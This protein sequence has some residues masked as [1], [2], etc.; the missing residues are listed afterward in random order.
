VLLRLSTGAAILLEG[1]ELS[2]TLGLAG[3]SVG[4]LMGA[5]AAGPS[6]LITACCLHRDETGWLGR[7]LA[8]AEGAAAGPPA[9]G[10]S[11]GGEQ[12]GGQEATGVKQEEQQQQEEEEGKAGVVPEDGAAIELRPPDVGEG[13]DGPQQP[14]EHPAQ[15][16]G[17]GE[18]YVAVARRGGAL[19]VWRVRDMR[20]VFEGSAPLGMGP[21]LLGCKGSSSDSGVAGAAPAAPAQAQAPGGGRGGAVFLDHPSTRVVEI[22][23]ESFQVGGAPCQVLHK[24]MQEHEVAFAAEHSSLVV[25]A[26]LLSQGPDPLPAC[27]RP[28]LVG[29]TAAGG[30]LAY[31]AF[32]RAS[33]VGAAPPRPL[34]KEPG[35]SSS[36]RDI[37]SSS[38]EAEDDVDM[39]EA[40]EQEAGGGVSAAPCCLRLA[41]K[42]MT[43]EWSSHA[44]PAVPANAPG[45]QAP[46]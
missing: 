37:H 9:G 32:D 27:E 28:V 2:M 44:D 38:K 20:L 25:P 6:A 10:G 22:R 1:D 43:F 15:G 21:P 36:S 4:P 29:L 24:P 39:P 5:P 13:D 35:S 16:Q 12:G 40:V 30:L 41:F 11:A 3:P 7:L 18:V 8:A 33:T 46:R 31:H 34:K 23:L 14:G 26:C 19:E 45:A 17:Q 42:R